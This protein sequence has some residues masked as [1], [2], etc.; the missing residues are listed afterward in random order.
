MS[1]CLYVRRCQQSCTVH[2]ISNLYHLESIRS[3]IEL[4]LMHKLALR[5]EWLSL[6]KLENLLK[7]EKN[8]LSMLNV[9]MFHDSTW[10]YSNLENEGCVPFCDRFERVSTAFSSSCTGIAKRLKL[11]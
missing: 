9:L 6:D 3:G 5:L 1:V 8:E 2:S 11:H 10:K 7:A 4:K